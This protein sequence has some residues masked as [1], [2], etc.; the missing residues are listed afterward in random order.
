MTHHPFPWHTV[1]FLL[2]FG[3]FIALV[4]VAGGW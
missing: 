3:V 2:S 4:I 1:I